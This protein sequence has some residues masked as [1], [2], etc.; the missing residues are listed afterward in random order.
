MSQVALVALLFAGAVQDGERD[1]IRVTPARPGDQ[2]VCV[3]RATIAVRDSGWTYFEA[4]FCDDVEAGHEE[5]SLLAFEIDCAN[6][7]SEGGEMRL[8]RIG[9]SMH[10][11]RV[12][13]RDNG[14]ELAK[15]VCAA[16]EPH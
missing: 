1:W 6:D 14:S 9:D 8:G 12:G 15:A 13:A 10:S 4:V 7:W 16:V 2:I 11:A 3:D 5:R